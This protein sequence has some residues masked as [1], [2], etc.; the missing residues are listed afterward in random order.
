VV[1]EGALHTERGEGAEKKRRSGIEMQKR[2]IGQ[3]DDDDDAS[4]MRWYNWWKKVT[5]HPGL[6]ID[7]FERID[8]K[9]EAYWLGFIYADAT[10]F[11]SRE[12]GESIIIMG[13]GKKDEDQLDRFCETL[14]LNKAK[15][16]YRTYE[17]SERVG[18]Q[19]SCKKMC[20]DLMKHGLTSRKSKII[21]Y[22]RQSLSSKELE[23]AFLL[24]YYDGDGT[25]NR[26][27]ITSSSKTFLEQIKRRFNLPYNVRENIGEGEICS[28]KIRLAT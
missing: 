1:N 11:V 5:V 12:T 17:G 3:F 28:R 20:N 6:R 18:I 2:R 9:T 25:R 14:R 26:T 16:F 8:D 24:G 23:L 27:I 19:F 13:L 10:L 4:M 7:Y 22:P 21:N 15:K